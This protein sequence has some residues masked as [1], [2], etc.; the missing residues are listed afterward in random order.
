MNMKKYVTPELE[1]VM[2]GDGMGM[3]IATSETFR[4]SSVGSLSNYDASYNDDS[5]IA[6]S[7]GEWSFDLAGALDSLSGAPHAASP[8]E[9]GS[10]WDE[11]GTDMPDAAM[12]DLLM[13]QLTVP[14]LSVPDVTAP[15]ITVPD[16]VVPDFVMPEL[17]VPEVAA[18][19]AD[20]FDWTDGAVD[21]VV[22][23][24]SSEFG[25]G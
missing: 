8:D 9:G 16:V 3:V 11:P 1:V 5:G 24:P 23:V 12:P 15:D 13:P 14:E 22:D 4:S 6:P 2:L 10:V 21:P 19:E 20:S 7:T 17:S 18:P 25:E